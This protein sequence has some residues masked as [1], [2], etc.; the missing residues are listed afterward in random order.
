MKN[1]YIRLYSIKLFSDP[2]SQLLTIF[3][4]AFTVVI[5]NYLYNVKAFGA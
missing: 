1:D 3:K 4:P 2:V 5:D